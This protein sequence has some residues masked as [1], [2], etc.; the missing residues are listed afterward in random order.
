MAGVEA[1]R[2]NKPRFD[3]DE[4]DKGLRE[5]GTMGPLAQLSSRRAISK[6][7]GPMPCRKGGGDQADLL[8]TL[9]IMTQIPKSIK[10]M[11]EEFL[12]TK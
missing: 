10:W 4:V 5:K 8:F 12:R 9:E 6:E 2:I 7:K 3:L 1:I 11:V